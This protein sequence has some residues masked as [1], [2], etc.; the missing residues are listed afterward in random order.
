MKGT[1]KL[2]SRCSLIVSA[3]LIVGI[4][5]LSSQSLAAIKTQDQHSD[6]NKVLLQSHVRTCQTQEIAHV[7]RSVQVSG[8]HNAGSE[9]RAAL[10][11]LRNHQCAHQ[12]L[13][14][15]P[16]LAA[17]DLTAPNANQITASAENSANSEGRVQAFDNTADSKWLTFAPR[18]WL[19]YDVLQGAK[20]VA[21]SVTS[22]N[23]EPARDPRDWQLE[24]S[25]DGQSWASID[26]QLA[27]SFSQRKLRRQYAVNQSV[28]YRYY[29][30]NIINNNGAAETQLA[31]LELIG[32]LD[33]NSSNTTVV[34]QNG[35]P[36]SGLSGAKDSN[37]KFRI[38][39][40]SGQKNLSFK[41]SG[42]SGDADLFVKFG[43]PASNTSFDCKSDGP[44]TTESCSFATPQTGT[45]YLN[46]NGYSAYSGA[47]LVA[48]YEAATCT[49]CGAWNKP[50]VDFRNDLSPGGLKFNQLV[51]DVNSYIQII[52]ENVQK[53][54]YHNASEVPAF[55]T[56]ELHIERWETEPNGVAWKAG[57]PPRIIVNVNA[58]HLERIAA[59][60]GDVAE[61]VRGIL[62]HEMT[63][64][65]Q[66]STGVDLPA[67]EGLAD[68]VRYLN[69]YIPTS[70]RHTGGSWTDSYKTTAFFFAWIK[71]RKGYPDFPY[72]FNQQGRPGNS[73]WSWDGAMRACTGGNTTQALWNEYQS[74]LASG[75]P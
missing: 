52:A 32:N 3:S 63:H 48:T 29:R 12:T 36:Q 39:V 22:A 40:P 53:T 54:I 68:T 65:Y 62:F 13:A 71:E 2:S 10:S 55:S 47:S 70:F 73:G 45:Y 7:M 18:G 25:N 43:S 61:E 26:A 33:S 16:T 4:N 34:L 5:S 66:F 49:N 46:L 74:W 24:G 56:L 19:R 72:C 57:D 20:L 6:V 60:G 17:T 35:V 28:S 58:Y 44:T 14:A 11:A 41:L 1:L 42:G 23:D 75:A 31:E 50:T 38:D 27:Q 30:F 8:K 15:A 37:K 21:Y 59:A 9:A 51:P 69:G 64:A 67:I